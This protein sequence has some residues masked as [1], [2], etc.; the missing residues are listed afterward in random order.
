ASRGAAA[1]F[2]KQGS[3]TPTIPDDA[4]FVGRVVDNAGG[5]SQRESKS[6]S[7]GNPGAR[8]QKNPTPREGA[9]TQLVQSGSFREATM[10]VSNSGNPLVIRPTATTTTETP[11]VSVQPPLP[12][13]PGIVEALGAKRGSQDDA[14]ERVCHVASCEQV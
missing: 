10:Y 12:V 8:S 14:H 5:C 2:L 11:C 1:N 9:N 13:L 3:S 6:P 4:V 7:L